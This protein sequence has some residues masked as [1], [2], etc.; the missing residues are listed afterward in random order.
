M[1]KTPFLLLAATMLLASCGAKPV[2]SISSSQESSASQESSSSQDPSSSGSSSEVKKA[3][4]TFNANGGEVSQTSMS[5]E[6]GKMAKLPLPTKANKT[7]R[8]WYTGWTGNDIHVTDYTAIECDLTLIA[9]W[10]SYD[11]TFKNGDGSGFYVE[12]VPH[13]GKAVAPEGE[14]TKAPGEE[15][16]YHFSGWSYDFS[17]IVYQD[18]TIDPIFTSEPTKTYV[19]EYASSYYAGTAQIKSVMKD[20]LFEASPRNYSQDLAELSCGAAF[21]TDSKEKINSFFTTLGWDTIE[22][23]SCY[24][25]GT[26]EDTIGYGIA[27]RKIGEYDVFACNIRGVEY[28]LEWSS[29]FQLGTYGTHSGFSAAAGQVRAEIRN[30]LNQH[31]KD[32]TAP[33]KFWIT[34]YS[35]GGA[36]ANVLAQDLLLNYSEDYTE[37][38]LYVYTFEAPGGL[39]ANRAVAWESV[40]NLIN[41][42]DLIPKI[43]PAQYGL[44][45]CGKDVELWDGHVDERL[46]AF[47]EDFKLPT[48]FVPN[49]QDYPTEPD[50]PSYIVKCLVEFGADTYAKHKAGDTEADVSNLLCDRSLYN[51]NYETHVRY[52]LS[53]FFGMPKAVLDSIIADVKAK[54]AENPLNVLM[55]LASGDSLYGYIKPFL[56][57]GQVAYDADKLLAA[58]NAAVALVTG[59]GTTV[60]PLAMNLPSLMRMIAL[61][62]P[63]T[64]YAI[65]ISKP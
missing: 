6:I 25:T 13:G 48:E 1:R 42:G 35:R 65:V 27:H 33:R 56:D 3:T 40:F 28:G 20:S 63:E 51:A 19:V 38:N 58:C 30:Y 53:L 59:P 8:G 32:A 44:G 49:R 18:G 29:N 4:L 9:M 26:K 60:L 23:A 24:D 62:M 55:L 64:V 45:R 11:V 61:H 31:F 36:V 2:P 41:G 46:A 57:D 14:P 47:K 10:D 17:T 16:A 22:T 50:F 34:G 37:D 54:F 43:L 52:L 39:E 7:F 12:A 5:V 15:V 21:A